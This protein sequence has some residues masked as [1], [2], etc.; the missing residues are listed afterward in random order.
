MRWYLFF[1]FIISLCHEMVASFSQDS[2]LARS[3]K[4]GQVYPLGDNSNESDR[5]FYPRPSQ[6]VD[7]EIDDMSACTGI[8]RT[9]E[10]KIKKNKKFFSCFQGCCSVSAVIRPH[11]V[12]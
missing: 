3:Y 6:K 4:D 7:Q 2:V 1:I 11:D 8:A 12:K 10:E 9:G 5:N